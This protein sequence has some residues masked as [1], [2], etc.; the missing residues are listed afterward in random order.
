MT[1]LADM[2]SGIRAALHRKALADA[3]Q[4]AALARRL[5]LTESEVLAVQHL[6]RAGELTPGQLGGLLQLSSG[7]TAGLIQRL[8]RA[9]HLSRHAHP[10]DRRSVVVRLTPTI[11]SWATD[12]WAPFVAEIDSLVEALA[13]DD[14]E[15]VRRFLDAT[16]QA[17]ERHADRLVHDANASAHDALAVALPAL[18]A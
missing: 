3:R 13:P 7:G 8:Q 15:V 4:R 17:A 16:V 9:G 14:R 12:T 11:A 1:D 2:P 5:R 18:W 10:H 6:A